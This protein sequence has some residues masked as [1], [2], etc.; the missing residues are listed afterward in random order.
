MI[1]FDRA[2]DELRRFLRPTLPT[3][4]D[5]DFLTTAE[6]LL[7]SRD[8]VEGRDA[9]S[10]PWV[11][12]LL[13][14]MALGQESF[15]NNNG[16]KIVDLNF[17]DDTAEWLKPLPPFQGDHPS[18]VFLSAAYQA[19]D[20]SSFHSSPNLQTIYAQ[21]LMGLYLVH[22]E[23]ASTFWPILGSIARQAQAIGLHV[24]PKYNPLPDQDLRRRIWWAI[25]QQD[26]LLSSIFGRPLAI[27]SFTCQITNPEKRNHINGGTS[28]LRV[29]SEF[30][31]LQRRYLMENLFD[32]WTD[33]QLDQFKNDLLAWYGSL[34]E[35]I[36][37]SVDQQSRLLDT[38]V[39]DKLYGKSFSAMETTIDHFI[40]MQY[41]LLT[42]YRNRL[43]SKDATFRQESYTI[44]GNVIHNIVTVLSTMIDLLGALQVGNVW[45]RIFYA[46]HSGIT[47]AFLCR[48]CPESQVAKQAK[49]DLTQLNLICQR[50]P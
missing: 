29:S 8:E 17:Q 33:E 50:L 5:D 23:R 45:L 13:M 6:E 39:C 20:L 15:A 18:D 11:A 47:A 21:I 43:H 7:L 34:P 24:E 27:S 42:L 41:T 16:G 46:S 9:I 1:P 25:V 31:M 19:L 38:N 30:A 48:T 37:I 3:L 14:I 12:V 44:C 40:E 49:E 4:L 10:L 32:E 36:C 28:C 26:V 22:T 2:F 35:V